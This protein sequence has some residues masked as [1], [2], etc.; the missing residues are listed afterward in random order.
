MASIVEWYEHAIDCV[1]VDLDGGGAGALA[2]L[3]P[4]ATARASTL[5]YDV[6]ED[7]FYLLS[8]NGWKPI[9][10]SGAS[11]PVV[12]QIVGAG[13]QTADDDAD[14]VTV[15]PQGGAVT[16]TIPTL[17][18]RTPGRRMQVIQVGAGTVAIV[19][20]DA[21]FTGTSAYVM[22][23]VNDA[24]ALSP[25]T[26][27]WRLIAQIGAPLTFEVWVSS[28]GDD[29]NV[30]TLAS[31][32]ATIAEALH[33]AAK[34]KWY[35]TARIRTLGAGLA[36]PNISIPAGIGSESGL[37]EIVGDVVVVTSGTVTAVTAGTVR[38]TMVV[39]QPGAG[40][41][42]SAF[43]GAVARF[44]IGGVPT[45]VGVF[46]NTIDALTTFRF[47]GATPAPGSTF[48]ILQNVTTLTGFS[49]INPG[50][51]F[52]VKFSRVNLSGGALAQ[53]CYVEFERVP[54]NVTIAAFFEQNCDVFTGLHAFGVLFYTLALGGVVNVGSMKCSGL[55]LHNISLQ[56]FKDNA[57][58]NQGLASGTSRFNVM[59]TADLRS[60]YC[61]GSTLASGTN[62][63]ESSGGYVFLQNATINN[64][65]GDAAI[66]A[67]NGRITM[68]GVQ[69]TG[70]ASPCVRAE[71]G[72]S[73]KVTDPDAVGGTTISS[74]VVGADVKVGANA[75]VAWPAIA[76]NSAASTTD[77]ANASSQMCRVGA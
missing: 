37:L 40:W 15:D 8:S 25:Q 65:S 58:V 21:I 17:A 16:L 11:A 20:A 5:S 23:R 72:S 9:G 61:N 50:T 7:V 19:G 66:C 45:E 46:D 3:I 73:I 41:T 54:F 63:V 33:R 76:T 24:I 47:T 60:I 14:V 27:G 26:G 6:D 42:P 38:S 30:G 1:Q 12:Q 59:A 49:Q 48:E 44:T 4:P 34:T 57:T 22:A 18:S 13:A 53:E 77:L 75:P 36:W 69:G 70:N 29:E 32:L 10:G 64:V 62:F 2:Q 31:P 56:V 55:G 74:V 39:T 43:R 67:K 52:R 51:G 68:S 28:A 71:S 35:T